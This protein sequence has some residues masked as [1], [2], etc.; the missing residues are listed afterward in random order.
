M[1]ERKSGAGAASCGS[2]GWP[3]DPDEEHESWFLLNQ[4]RDTMIRLRDREVRHLGITSMQG[5][6]LWVLRAM[7]EE[8]M[9]ATPAE[10]TL[11]E[12]EKRYRLLADN[13][14]DVILLLDMDFR[15]TCFSPSI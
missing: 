10:E 2:R 11:K 9:A 3:L 15:P 14:A 13:V 6:V 1:G 12:S 5:G 7:E 4:V 8:G